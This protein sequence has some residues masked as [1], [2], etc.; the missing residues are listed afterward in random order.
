MFDYKRTDGHYKIGLGTEPGL[1]DVVLLHRGT[2]TNAITLLRRSKS[3]L[4]EYD[5][6]IQIS[7]EEFYAADRSN[8][9]T[10]LTGTQGYK[11]DNTPDGTYTFPV[12]PTNTKS[13]FEIKQQITESLKPLTALE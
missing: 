5:K 10:P 3:N 1:F 9:T 11:I 12:T 6:Q 2:L 8:F 7:I 13:F 4:T